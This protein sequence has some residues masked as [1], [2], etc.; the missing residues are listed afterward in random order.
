MLYY[1]IMDEKINTFSKKTVKIIAQEIKLNHIFPF[2]NKETSSS[3]GSGFFIDDKGHILT[4]SHV[5]EHSKSILVEI[6]HLGDKKIEVVVLGL[7]PEFDLAVLKTVNYIPKDYYDLHKKEFIYSVKPSSEVYA[8]GFPLAQ[9]NLKFTRGIISGREDGLIQ[10]DAPINPGNSGGPLMFNDKVIGINTSGIDDA[11]NI[12]YATP[13]SYFFLIKNELFKKNNLIKVPIIGV[14]YQNTTDSMTNVNG[15]Y[16]KHV[17]RR[18][19]INKTGIQVGDILTHI[20]SYKIDNF[21]LINKEWFNEKMNIEDYIKT[22]PFGTKITIIFKRKETT[23]KKTFQFKAD[24]PCLSIVEKYPIWE[25]KPIDF[26]VFAGMVVMQLNYN[27]FKYLFKYLKNKIKNG[28]SG[29][30]NIVLKYFLKENREQPK[31]IVTK[32]LQ[33]CFIDRFSIIGDFEIL[34]KVN[35]LDVLTLHDYRKAILKNS[36]KL[37]IETEF[38]NKLVVRLAPLMKEEETFSKTYKYPLGIV[39]KKLKRRKKTKKKIN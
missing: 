8:V 15:V 9:K 36:S 22:I 30:D 1:Y 26:E 33:N 37:D 16:I 31:L 29:R 4:C 10:T 34:K 39:Y 13:I 20:N 19:V 25:K 24:V 21:G 2:K 3:V 18:S 12:G 38:G 35:G 27:H 32:I 23:F 14:L 17:F 7:C 11:N 5:I 6:P 28:I